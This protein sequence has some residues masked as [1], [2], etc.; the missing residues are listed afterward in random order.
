MWRVVLIRPNG[1]LDRKLALPKSLPVGGTFKTSPPPGYLLPI[2]SRKGFNLRVN[3]C[4]RTKEQ[5]IQ[6]DGIDNFLQRAMISSRIKKL[7]VKM[8]I[9]K[10]INHTF[11]LK[12]YHSDYLALKF[13]QII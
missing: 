13:F 8:T 12:S 1:L 10:S 4:I 11:M 7:R 6:N 3:K 5:E 2:S 9:I